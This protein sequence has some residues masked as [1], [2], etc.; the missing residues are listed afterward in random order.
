MMEDLQVSVEPGA[1]VLLTR[2]NH[3]LAEGGIQ[4][5]LIGGFVRDMLLGRDTADID[6]A[7]AANALE[8][9]SKVASAL[10]GKYVLLDEVN[11]VGRVVLLNNGTNPTKVK[12]ELDFST[13]KG[14]IEQ[15]LAQRDFTIDAMAFELGNI[16][17]SDERSRK[18]GKRD[19]VIVRLPGLIDPFK[20]WDDL[21]K[22]VIRAVS[23]TVFEADAVR[24]LRAVRLAAE[25]GFSIDSET[26]ALIQRC[27][28]LI[29]GVA[30]ERVRD[31]LLRI[32]AI[33]RAGQLLAY[34]D[35]LGLLTAMIPEM[36]QTKG[37]EQPLNHFWDV[38]DH[39]MQVIAAVDFL[40]RQGT[41]EYA[42]GEVLAA[43]PWSAVLGQ[44]FDREVSSGSTR[45]SLL[46]LAALLHDIAKPQTKAIDENGRAR[47]LGHPREGAAIAADILERLRFS[48]KEIKLVELLVE[49]HLRPGQMSHYEFPSRRA[50]YRYFRDT[51][52]AG[53]DILFLSLAD[54]LATKG[55]QLDLAHWQE[56]TRVVEYV[57]AR[58]LEEESS[59]VPPKLIDGHDLVDIFGLHPGPGIGKLLEGVHEAQAIGEVTT[60]EGALA[61]IR[62][63]LTHPLQNSIK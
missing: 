43:V 36:A 5:Y 3:V 42:G 56:H 51:G 54:H 11:G 16:V 20:G 10:G 25:L 48:S 40:L 41:L 19:E 7:V 63:L 53:I 59:I 28:H 29:S 34:L 24:L 49:Y 57:L 18:P 61:Y 58:Y 45:K 22:G 9:A 6:I 55:P 32:L 12:R 26:E 23:G 47:F 27:C 1:S 13:L 4:S 30:G 52:E 60:K 38:F 46:K 50:I 8:V 14:D 44:H 15:D 37:V 2:V 39:S 62:H 17:L 31:E 21:K 33:P 35:K